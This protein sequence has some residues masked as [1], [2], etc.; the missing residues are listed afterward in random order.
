MTADPRII[1]VG[2]E[3]P[4]LL[5]PMNLP[6]VTPPG[7]CGRMAGHRAE[8]RARP[9]DGQARCGSVSRCGSAFA[10]L[11]AFLDEAVPNL[12]RA[13]LAAWLLLFRHAK[14]DGVVSASVLDLARRAGCNESTMRRAL[15]RL[16]AKGLACRIKRG[17]LAGGPSIWRLLPPEGTARDRG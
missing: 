5:T 12:A 6:N 1:P 8:R 9:Q 3:P 10:L 13:E 7:R 15:Q 16:Q 2:A 14:P 17:S 11:N 4:P